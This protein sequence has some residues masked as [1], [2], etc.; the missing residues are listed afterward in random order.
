[1]P[2]DCAHLLPPLCFMS[3]CLVLVSVC[4]AVYRSNDDGM[5]W[6]NES[7]GNFI[8]SLLLLYEWSIRLV[9]RTV[10]SVGL[11]AAAGFVQSKQ[12]KSWQN[13]VTKWVNY[14]DTFTQIC[15]ESEICHIPA[16]HSVIDRCRAMWL[17]SNNWFVS[18]RTD[19]LTARRFLSHFIPHF[20]CEEASLVS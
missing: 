6:K 3:L 16:S 7:S 15:T 1:M 19:V 9:G 8:V 11:L 20:L 10:L 4:Q 17:K 2:S 18:C 14:C 12:H 13:S 5:K